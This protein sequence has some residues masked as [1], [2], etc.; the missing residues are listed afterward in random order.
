MVGRALVLVPME[1]L[2]N[3]HLLSGRPL[4]KG[5]R[6]WFQ[7]GHFSLQ[8]KQITETFR[9]RRKK[10]TTKISNPKTSYSGYTRMIKFSYQNPP[11]KNNPKFWFGPTWKVFFE[12]SRLL[13]TNFD[14]TRPKPRL[15][16]TVRSRCFLLL[17]SGVLIHPKTAPVPKL[18]T[19]YTPGSTNIVG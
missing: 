2:E 10:G 11:N 9:E 16:G 3:E 14:V 15:L 17:D 18:R 8:E 7:G 12:N 5:F 1:R 19:K 4:F 6:C 13:P